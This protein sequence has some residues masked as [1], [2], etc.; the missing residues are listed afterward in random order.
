[1][2]I[3]DFLAQVSSER[4]MDHLGE[5]ARFIKLSGTAEELESLKLLERRMQAA[6]FGTE[7][8]FHDAW[9]SLPGKASL[10]VGGT[11][12]PCI[13]HSMAAP[14]TGLSAECVWVGAGTEA[15]FARSDVAG[16]IAVIDGIAFEDVTLLA[17][18]AG[19]VGQIQINPA[20][21]RH[22]MCISPVWGSPGP[23]E[24]G[25]LPTTVV[26]SVT[27]ADGA[28]LRAACQRGA[29]PLATIVAEVDTG[30][31]KTPILVAEKNCDGNAPFVMLSGHHDTWYYG[32][33]DN[34]A[35]DATIAETARVLAQDVGAWQ[36]GLRVCFWS[37]HSHGRYSGSSWYADE[38]WQDLRAR[39]VAHVNVD[40][41]GGIGADILTRSGTTAQLARIVADAVRQETGQVHEGRRQGRAADQSFWGIG[42]AS[43]FGSVSHWSKMPAGMPVSLGPY[44]HTPDDLIDHIDPGHLARDTRIVLNVTAQLLTG[45]RLPLDHLKWCDELADLLARKSGEVQGR[46]DLSGAMTAVQA[47]R[48]VLAG[49]VAAAPAPVFNEAMRVAAH[50]LI[51]IDHVDGG[52]YTPDLAVPRRPWDRLAAIDRLISA[53]GEDVRA[54]TIDAKRA[55]NRLIDDLDRCAAALAHILQ[56]KN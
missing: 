8:L 25:L 49:P 47:L 6:G 2:A 14:T 51:P 18:R 27:E 19:A 31:R 7:I 10:T 39:C 24:A 12:I 41:T 29:R 37:G 32:V 4:M 38:Y 3:D 16:K 34:G 22:E 15:D 28:P 17:R 53:S 1:M 44:W 11:D 55:R 21:R 40:S 35:A 54:A 52:G 36:R 45:E 50:W 56:N 26:V 9:I 46:L 48:A 5:L 42:I 33:M 20:Q 23:Q 13:T 43:C 30:W